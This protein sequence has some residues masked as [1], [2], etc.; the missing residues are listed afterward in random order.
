MDLVMEKGEAMV[1]NQ[2]NEEIEIDRRYDE[3]TD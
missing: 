1:V 3:I 2:Q